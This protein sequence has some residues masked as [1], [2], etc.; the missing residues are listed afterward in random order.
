MTFW[1][2][3][4]IDF[5]TDQNFH[6]F[7]DLDTG[8]GLHRIMSGFH[9]AFTLPTCDAYRIWHSPKF[10]LPTWRGF[11]RIY[12]TGVACQQGTLT[13]PDTWSCPTLGLACVLMSR[14]ISP[15]LVLSPDLWIS[16]TPRYFSFACNGCCMPAGN[17]Y[18]F[19]HLV[20]SPIFR[21]CL[22]SNCWDQFPR[23][24]HVLSRLFTLNTPWYFLG[25]A[26]E[27]ELSFPW[28]Y[29]YVV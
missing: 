20:P 4:K 24:C 29:M 3:T 19:G 2:F 18:P 14:P 16:N 5:S 26:F 13:P 27:L 8:R 21:T 22:C 10:T 11:N 7:Y 1:P 15:E 12:A 23:T 28:K 9:G 6:Q 25:F 17:A